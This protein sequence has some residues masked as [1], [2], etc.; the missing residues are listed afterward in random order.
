MRFTHTL[1][2]AFFAIGLVAAANAFG[3]S[4]GIASDEM[5]LD[6]QSGFDIT[7]TAYSQSEYTDQNPGFFGS[8]SDTTLGWVN[9]SFNDVPYLNRSEGVSDAWEG[10]SPSYD[11]NYEYGT[12]FFYLLNSG[13]QAEYAVIDLDN[14]LES[15]ATG[16]DDQSWG[17]AW[18]GTEL[19]NQSTGEYFYAD[20]TTFAGLGEQ[21]WVE[22]N[23]DY[24]YDGVTSNDPSLTY[25]GVNQI[26]TGDADWNGEYV[27]L[28]QP[29]QAEYLYDYEFTEHWASFTPA[30]SSTP[31]PVAI[32]PFALGMLAARRRR[33]A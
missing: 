24:N 23:L 3:A 30:T 1:F 26:V 7:L 25:F 20:A 8:Y 13:S 16:T 18:S 21:S 31:G 4:G 15:A 33:R 17:E 11:Q 19:F 9:G 32:A 12:T 29:G 28:L 10:A 22:T 27:A 14:E 5:G 2:S 6:S